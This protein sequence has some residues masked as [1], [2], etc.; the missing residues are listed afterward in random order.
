[1]AQEG[2]RLPEAEPSHGAYRQRAAGTDQPGQRATHDSK[3]L[4]AVDSSEIGDRAIEA[5]FKATDVFNRHRSCVNAT[6]AG[7]PD[8]LRRAVNPLNADAGLHQM[9]S[10]L[11]GPAT[12][13]KDGIAGSKQPVD[14]P[15]DGGS[16][17]LADGRVG[18]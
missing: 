16:L 9:Q 6:R 12:E 8:H 13:V 15:P 2:R 18:P 7:D 3:V 1:M 4:D 11:A 14:V 10:V 5:S 17:E